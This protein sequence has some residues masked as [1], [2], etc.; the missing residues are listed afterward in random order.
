LINGL[1]EYWND[2]LM[3]P[4]IQYSNIP[5]FQLFMKSLNDTNRLRLFHT[6]M[7]D[8]LLEELHVPSGMD[9]KDRALV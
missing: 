3:G 7:D 1:M 8:R 2:V 9:K 5:I 6:T 4:I